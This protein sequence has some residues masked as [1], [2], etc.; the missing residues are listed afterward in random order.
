MVL[1]QG[2]GNF[3]SYNFVD[4]RRKREKKTSHKK[5]FFWVVIGTGLV[6][7]VNKVDKEEGGNAKREGR[8]QRGSGSK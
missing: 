3:R 4:P 8:A 2:G 5:R 1:L 7:A 6:N